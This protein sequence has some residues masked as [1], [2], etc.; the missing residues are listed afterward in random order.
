M[1]KRYTS[2]FLASLIAVFAI[3]LAGCASPAAP[4]EDMAAE[5]SAAAPAPETADAAE[6][7]TEGDEIG[8]AHV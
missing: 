8:R 3:I 4:T 2:I 7:P 5:E 1:H 6:E